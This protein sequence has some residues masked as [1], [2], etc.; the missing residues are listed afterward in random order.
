LGDG[1]QEFLDEISGNLKDQAGF[2]GQYLGLPATPSVLETT[3]VI[4]SIAGRV[5]DCLTPTAVYQ[6]D[7]S[8]AA[9]CVRV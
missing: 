9:L 3:P 5:V 6:V 2:G 8:F 7:T 4:L 1:Q